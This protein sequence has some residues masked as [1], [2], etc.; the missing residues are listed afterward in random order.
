MS[1]VL[2]CACLCSVYL[3]ACLSTCILPSY[4]LW[5]NPTSPL[6]VHRFSGSWQFRRCE[7]NAVIICRVFSCHNCVA[8]CPCP[9]PTLK[10]RQGWQEGLTS[11]LCIT[12]LWYYIFVDC[13]SVFHSVTNMPV[14]GNPCTV[15]TLSFSEDCKYKS[16]QSLIK[17]MIDVCHHTR[18]SHAHFP[19]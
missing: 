12:S 8:F 6:H 4:V 9:H 18:K 16:L 17:K 2:A 13:G 15:H 5:D 3:A 10:S 1:T 14:T 19:V 7:I 11:L